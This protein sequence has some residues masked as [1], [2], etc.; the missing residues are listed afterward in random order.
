MKCAQAMI[1]GKC[2][3]TA[4]EIAAKP[5]IHVAHPWCKPVGTISTPLSLDTDGLQLNH[6]RSM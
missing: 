5:G 4:V 6:T 1:L 2:K 3:V